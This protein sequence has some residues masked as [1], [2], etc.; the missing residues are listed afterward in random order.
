[1]PAPD[2][3]VELDEP[4]WLWKGNI[5]SLNG[6][7]AVSITVVI[8]AHAVP[9]AGISES[10]L[11]LSGATGVDVFFVIS[12]FL[13]TLL[14]LREQKRFGVISIPKFYAR[15][16]L[17]I[18]PAYFTYLGVITGLSILGMI[19]IRSTELLKAATYTTNL[20]PRATWDV[21]HSWSLCVEEHFYLIWPLT[22]VCAGRFWA[23]RL[24]ALYVLLTPFIRVLVLLA[25]KTQ[26]A[27]WSFTLTRMDAIAVGCCLAFAVTSSRVRQRVRLTPW[28]VALLC[29]ACGGFLVIS[30]FIL[31]RYQLQFKAVGYYAAVLSGTVNALAI[32]A[33]VWC[34]VLYP[35]GI[36]GRFLNSVPAIFIGSLSYS[37]YLWQQ[38][39]FNPDRDTWL[40]DFPVNVLAVA[41]LSIG[42]YYLIERPFLALKQRVVSE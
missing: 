13:I 15:R 36:L 34:C 19:D 8:L 30:Q 10:Y 22:L 12:G 23:P 31:V 18:F 40:F 42:S 20:F 32:G 39:L 3:L 5:P 35:V 1:M 9:K 29:A 27:L 28:Q 17:R 37:L 6:L 7:R 24:A 33:A 4:P 11:P 26:F 14:L 2:A 38:P 16:T 25:F 41:V 21:G